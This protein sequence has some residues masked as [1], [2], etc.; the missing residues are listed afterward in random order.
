M[1]QE[2]PGK[3]ARSAEAKSARRAQILD[4]ATGLLE[5]QE[6]ETVVMDEVAR[7]AG[8]AKGTLYLYFRTKEELFLGLVERAFEAWFDELDAKLGTGQGWIPASALADLVTETLTPRL[9]FR[10]LLARLGP[11]L[12][13][14]LADDRALRFKW[15]IAG[16]LAM[17]GALLERRTVYLRQGDGPR[18]LLHLQAL[19]A[20]I[21][22]LSDPAPPVRRILQAPGLDAM[23]M[24]FEREFRAAAGRM[25]TGLERT[26]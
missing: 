22:A 21:Q 5:T 17:T 19:A 8:V 26:N 7:K 9:L 25:L 18:V 11:V 3:R 10:R 23:R 2:K 13:H 6:L 1:G 12:E 4:G 24:D 20:G 14:N 15:R 16:R